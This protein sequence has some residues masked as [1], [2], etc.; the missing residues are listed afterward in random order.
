MEEHDIFYVID[1]YCGFRLEDEEHHINPGEVAI[2]PAN[3]PHYGSGRYR[4]NTHTIFVHFS[5]R[6]GDH[7]P[8]PGEQ[9]EGLLLRSCVHARSPVIYQYFQDLERAYWSDLSYREFRCSAI[10]G[11]LLMELHDCCRNEGIRQNETIL[12]LIDLM[13][14]QPHRFFTIQELADH[15]DMSPKSLTSRFKAETGQTIHQYQMNKKL[16]Q[17]A[18]LLRGE[19]GSRLKNLADNFGFYDEFHLSSS[20]RKK[21]G[22]S[23]SQFSQ[24][25]SYPFDPAVT[26]CKR[27]LDDSLKFSNLLHLSTGGISFLGGKRARGTPGGRRL[28]FKFR[29]AQGRDCMVRLWTAF[30]V[31]AASL[32]DAAGIERQEG[33]RLSRDGREIT[34]PIT[35]G[36]IAA[37]LLELPENAAFSFTNKL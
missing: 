16:Y 8:A 24:N 21:F 10:L 17:I 11:L 30:S 2:L 31:T 4:A 37:V 36:S 26:G 3:H 14:R 1:G 29:E 27:Q 5:V 7:R 22:I 34:F 13:S 15:A 12:S 19:A 6:P 9:P 20:F 28:I 18:A 35:A 25:P 32:T 33:C 23:P